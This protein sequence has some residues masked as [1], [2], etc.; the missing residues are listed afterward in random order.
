M[1]PKGYRVRIIEAVDNSQRH[2]VDPLGEFE[3]IG[4]LY[5]IVRDV[6]RSPHVSVG[7]GDDCAA[8]HRGDRTDVYTTDALVDGVH[9]KLGQIPWSDLGWKAIAVSLSDI[10]AM[11]AEALHTLVTV[12]LP[13]GLDDAAVMAIYQG[14]AEITRG[15]GGAVIGGDVVRS[16]VLFISVTAVGTT[17]GELMLRSGARP[18]DRIAVTGVV[19]DSAGGRRAL[20]RGLGGSGAGCLKRAHFRPAPRTEVGP[21]LAAAGV[22]VAIDVS[23]GLLG[24]LEKLCSASGVRAEVEAGAVPASASLRE[25]F[26]EEWLELALSGGEDYELLVTAP[27][28][29]LERVRGSMGCPITV[30]GEIRSP[31]SRPEGTV[32]VVDGSGADM[33][34]AG[35]GWDHLR[36]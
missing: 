17:A 4:K 1:S 6:P 26:P 19:G 13:K 30:V 16:P 12:G 24:D 31:G 21:R 29:L 10:A 18:G 3:L 2:A 7:I 32:R 25:L 34:L 23:D 5:D 35:R 14:M 15:H 22:R 27:R 33:T 36:G 20:D 28:D 9:F 8:V 11:G